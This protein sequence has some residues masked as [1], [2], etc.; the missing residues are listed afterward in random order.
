MVFVSIAN[1]IAEPMR[2]DTL[3]IT[4]YHQTQFTIFAFYEILL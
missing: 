3:A 1:A 2:G 4:P